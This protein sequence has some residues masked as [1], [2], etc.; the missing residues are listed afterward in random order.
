MSIK[1]QTDP[2]LWLKAVI[3]E[4]I[5]RSPEN[6]LQNDANEK[7]FEDPLVGFSR[8]NDPLYEAY[9]E[10]VGPFH[11]TPR[12]I[13]TRTFPGL[14]VNPDELT[15]ISWILPQTEA[16]KEDNRKES[17]YLSQR[18]ARAAYSA[19]RSMTS[20]ENMWWMP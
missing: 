9:K 11:R 13:F 10:H 5:G 1:Q 4:F 18:W 8:G 14:S 3:Q 19:K 15:V 6:T 2:G 12:E 16:T 20:S 7:A 17:T